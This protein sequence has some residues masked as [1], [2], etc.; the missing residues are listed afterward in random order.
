[1][2]D[3]KIFVDGQCVHRDVKE[4]LLD[5][6]PG[7]VADAMDC[8]IWSWRWPFRKHLKL[9]PE[10]IDVMIFWDD[11]STMDTFDMF[12]NTQ[13]IV[14]V[15]TYDYRDR[16]ANMSR[17]ITHIA[18]RIKEVADTASDDEFAVTITFIPVKT[19]H[20]ARA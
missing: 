10:N 20:W 18:R 19:S 1:M 2:P 9:K 16:K 5:K 8:W 11:E 6:A 13:I 12:S 7:I 3:V 4:D 14:E 15:A 17:R